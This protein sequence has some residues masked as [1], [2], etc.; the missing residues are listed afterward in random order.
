[1][2]WW[3]FDIETE[4]WTHLV[5]GC[6]L[7]DDGRVID[8][9]CDADVEAWYGSLPESDIVWAHNGGGF[10]F[11]YLISICRPPHYHWTARMAGSSII[12]CRA[13]AHAECRDTSRLFPG[14]LAKWTRQKSDPGLTCECGKA[15]GGWCQLRRDMPAERRKRV[16]DYCL[17]DCRALLDTLRADLSRLQDEGLAILTPKGLPRLTFGGVA[18]HTVAPDVPGGEDP[19]AWAEYDAGRRAYYGG[20]CEVGRVRA[21]VGYRYDVHAMYPWALTL[22]VPHGER[23]QRMGR[24]ASRAF[25]CMVPG[26]YHARVRIPETDLPPLPHRYSERRNR[27]RLTRGRLLWCTGHVTGWWTTIELAA[28]ERHGARIE[29]IVSANTW[30]DFDPIYDPYVRMI[31]AARDAARTAGDDRW[32]GILKFYANAL[33]GKLA[34]RPTIS[35][36]QVTKH[37]SEGW[38][39]LGGDVWCR[40]SR[41]LSPCSRPIQAAYL[42]SRARE[43]LLDRLMRHR[44][45]WLYCD[46]DST[47]LT[48]QD[49]RD[50]HESELGTFGYEGE[51]REWRALAPKLYRYRDEGGADHVRAKGIPRPDWQTIDDLSKGIAIERQ[52]GV[53]RIK[54]SLGQFTRRELVR[55]FRDHASDRC[56]TRFVNPDGTTRPLHRSRG[57]KY[58]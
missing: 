54:S 52:V 49:D 51:A 13:K 22:P 4:A 21:D 55:S 39:H 45:E 42:T 37:P 48:R 41:R 34:Q 20:R 58:R 57:G 50:V 17:Q 25:D 16:R 12:S 14:S 7:A 18:W 40:H 11:L 9:S 43:R 56:G 36:L 24:S 26:A 2:T 33:S 28:A 1:M 53:E 5:L 8:F 46:T 44:G 32:A 35:A 19:V 29:C 15:C 27:E 30:S 10:D 31:Y 47:Y 23:T 3:A 6:A 38:D